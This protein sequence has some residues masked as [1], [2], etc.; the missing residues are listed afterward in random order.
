[1]K[2][3]TTIISDDWIKENKPCK[4]AVD[5]WWDKKE[6]KPIKILKLLIKDK[7]YDWANWFI[8]RIMEYKD[9]V[10][11]TVFA[12]ESVLDIYEEKYPNDKRPRQAI[13]AAKK[14]IKNPSKENK[15]TAYAAAY[16][17]ARA[18]D[19]AADAAA[20]AA[21]AAAY[22]ADAAYAAAYAAARV[23]SAAAYAAAD[24]AAD[25]AASAAAYAADAAIK[26]KILKYGIKLLEVKNV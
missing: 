12:A 1:M 8:V 20:S 6:R 14:C 19:A 25:A 10:S 15:K 3:I 9:Y 18:A 17:A 21:D 22:A 2:S 13:E 16:A 4:E 7:K 23:A 5:T 24:A 11:Y 26:L